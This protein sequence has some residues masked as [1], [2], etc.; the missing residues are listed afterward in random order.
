MTQ[1][2]IAI[3]LGISKPTLAKHYERE[4]S[5]GAYERRIEV[6]EALH[7][8][9]VKGNASAAR[10]YLSGIPEAAPPPIEVG[11]PAPENVQPDQGAAPEML[12]PP[13]LG[14]KEQAKVDARSAQDGTDW[15]DLLPRRSTVQ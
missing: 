9:G 12:A 13:K 5:V 3:G 1:E 4:L 11:A 10:Q 6:L 2:E 14:K 15:A 7:A 8:G